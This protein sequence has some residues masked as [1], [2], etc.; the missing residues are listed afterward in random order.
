MEARIDSDDLLHEPNISR[1]NR[2]SGDTDQALH[3]LRI[4]IV[5]HLRVCF[6]RHTLVHASKL[7][8]RRPGP[9]E[10]GGARLH[11]GGDR[12]LEWVVL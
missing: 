11:V 3:P 12:V 4:D 8:P 1:C 5:K 7:H 6:D 2:R 10:L 9:H